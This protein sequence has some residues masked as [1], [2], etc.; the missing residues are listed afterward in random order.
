MNVSFNYADSVQN[1]QLSCLLLCV[2]S[3]SMVRIST[4]H[5]TSYLPLLLLVVVFYKAALV[6][7][8]NVTWKLNAVENGD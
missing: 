5:T 8:R 7:S 4:F 2:C 3:F 6:R 1:F